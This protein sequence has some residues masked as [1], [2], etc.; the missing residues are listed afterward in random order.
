MSE[1]Q[2]IKEQ[3]L[4][5]RKQKRYSE[6]VNLYEEL[7]SNHRDGCNE[8]EGW[9]FATC[10]RKVGNPEKALEICRSI[11]QLTPDFEAGKNLYS[12]CIYDTEIKKDNEQIEQDEGQ[13]FKAA[14]AIF[15][16]TI[17][18]Q[19]SPYTKTVFRVIGYLTKTK[20]SYSASDIFH[21]IDKLGPNALSKEPFSFVGKDQKNRE[22]PSD[23]ERWYAIKTKALEKNGD[24]QECV[25]LSEKAL[26]DFKKFHHGNNIWFKRRIALSK[27]QLGH[28]K[29]AAEELE[30]ILQDRKE[31]FIQHELAQIYY[32]LG[33]TE[34][35]LANAIEAALNFGNNEN[36]WELFVLM[37]RILRG[38]G[39]VEKARNH[40][41]FAVNLREEHG[42]KIPESLGNMVDA[43][44]LDSQGS[45]EKK[46]LFKKLKMFWKAEK[47][48]SLPFMNGFVK[49]ILKNGKAGFI[50]GDDK[51]DYFFKINGFKGDRRKLTRGLK[52]KFN[53]E[54]SF[55][56]KKNV[57][58]K[59]ATNIREIIK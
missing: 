25:E 39:K 52:V 32:D 30:I 35:A 10:L 22:M 41:A 8:W 9:G 50:S 40:L 12:W 46:E 4:E 15:K 2:N 44:N 27:A 16:L 1:F 48:S 36:K 18:D 51:K 3:A 20:T 55:D 26:K 13:F 19:Y 21:W 45:V 34:K 54:D 24:F 33:E 5:L 6:A 57:K 38:Q 53:I 43:F 28:K 23:Q 37:A 42:W 47:Y 59:A 49:I 17:Q 56:R 11:Y 58:T 31:W 14:N 7:W 29:Q